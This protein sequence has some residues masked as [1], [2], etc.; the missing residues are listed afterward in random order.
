MDVRALRSQF[1]G[2]VPAVLDNQADATDIST[3]LKSLLEAVL[4]DP[5]WRGAVTDP[6]ADLGVRWQFLLAYLGERWVVERWNDGQVVEC[7]LAPTLTLTITLPQGR[8]ATYAANSTDHGP[9]VP[10]PRVYGTPPQ[11]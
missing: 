6:V 3:A 7:Y 2:I 1:E 10:R 11:T 8:T 5:R 9:P 4:D